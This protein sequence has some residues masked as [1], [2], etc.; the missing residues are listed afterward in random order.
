MDL[1][2]SNKGSTDGEAAAL[3]SSHVEREARRRLTLDEQKR[4]YKNTIP[5]P[6]SPFSARMR[7]TRADGYRP[8]DA[9]HW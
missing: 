1:S 2:D 9:R 8:V 4:T 6:P 7:D 3:S 5:S